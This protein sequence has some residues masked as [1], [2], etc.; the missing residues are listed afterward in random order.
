M[1]IY[2]NLTSITKTH[3]S[4]CKKASK[5]LLKEGTWGA[6]IYSF[7][8]TVIIFLCVSPQFFNKSSD[9]YHQY[10]I[11]G[12]ANALAESFRVF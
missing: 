9:L 5:V 2:A 7:E 4:N 6:T 12:K 8:I 1:H 10:N 11:L 3:L